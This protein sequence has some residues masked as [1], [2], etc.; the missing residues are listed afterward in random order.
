MTLEELTNQLEWHEEREDFETCI[1]IKKYIDAK[2][3]R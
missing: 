3:K 1:I 2:S